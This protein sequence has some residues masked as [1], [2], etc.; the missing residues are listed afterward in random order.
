MTEEP[1]DRSEGEG[2]EPGEEE[3]Q[4]DIAELPSQLPQDPSEV[5]RRYDHQPGQR[6]VAG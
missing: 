5:Y 4:D 6:R 1:Y 2:Y 3:E